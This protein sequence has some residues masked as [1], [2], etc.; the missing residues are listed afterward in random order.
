MVV[1]RK[2]FSFFLF[3]SSREDRTGLPP[4]KLLCWLRAE[5]PKVSDRPCCIRSVLAKGQLPRRRLSGRLP[6][7]APGL[8]A[9]GCRSIDLPHPR[10]Q[11][12]DRWFGQ[13][14]A[15]LAPPAHPVCRQCTVRSANHGPA[16]RCAPCPG[17]TGQ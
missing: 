8:T 1:D 9:P 12:P 10:R 3:I 17:A 6:P 7:Q 2:H 4:P 13:T 14:A 11:I 5:T 15:T 16:T